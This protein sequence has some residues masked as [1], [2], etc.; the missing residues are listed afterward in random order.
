MSQILVA[1]RLP[2][3]C[4]IT[5]VQ[6]TALTPN[7]VLRLPVQYVV[8]NWDNPPK[9][10]S[11]I[12]PIQGVTQPGKDGHVASMFIKDSF[13]LIV[14]TVD[15][16]PG[17]LLAN[18][19]KRSIRAQLFTR[20]PDVFYWPS[21]GEMEARIPEWVARLLSK[22]IT[23][24]ANRGG[25]VATDNV[26]RDI[27]V[28]SDRR[29]GS[30]NNLLWEMIHAVGVDPENRYFLA[31]DGDPRALVP[32]DVEWWV[33]YADYM[34]GTMVGAYVTADMLHASGGALKPEYLLT[35]FTFKK[36]GMLPEPK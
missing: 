5:E 10:W 13:A 2:H 3:N 30:K 28:H 33:R 26:L 21:V 8:T 22:M 20:T 32:K 31:A 7:E 12:W 6:G 17:R 4:E 29:Y 15:D 16:D 19:G 9:P 25:I 1:D 18:A 27:W 24:Q 23:C 14:F 11:A 35:E 34:I 36:T